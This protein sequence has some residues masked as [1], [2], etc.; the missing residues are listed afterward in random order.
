MSEYTLETFMGEVQELVG[1]LDEPADCVEAV[2][3]LLHRL[4]NGSRVNAGVKV[5]HWPA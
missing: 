2:A 4:I 1:R 3:P 5:H